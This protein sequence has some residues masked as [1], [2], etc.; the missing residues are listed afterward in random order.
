MLPTVALIGRPNVGKSTLFNRLLGRNKAL[1]HDRPGVTRDRIYAEVRAK[2]VRPFALVDTGGLVFTDAEGFELDVL[3]QAREAIRGSQAALLVVDAREGLT[4]M[5]QE[6]AGFLRSAG[7][8]LLCAANKVDGPEKE[9]LGAEFH[10][11]G[12]DVIPV[13]AAHGFGV[14]TLLQAVDD[15]LGGLRDARDGDWWA[16]EEDRPD[17]GL[18]MTMLGRPN[19]GKSSMVNALM[20][21]NRLIVSE[22]AGTTRD[23]VDVTFER[24]GKR[25][26]FV[27]TAGVRRRGRITD[28]LERFSTLRALRASKHAQVTVMVLDAT[29]GV[30][31]QDKKLLAFLDKEKT[32]FLAAVNKVDLVPRGALAQLRKDFEETLRICPHVPV[33]YTS[34]V[35]RA[36]LGGLLPLAEQIWEECGLRVGTGELNRAMKSALERHQPPTVKRRRAKFY[37]LTQPETHPPGFV[38]F[39]NDKDLVKESY[40]RYLEN[41]LRKMLGVKAAPMRVIFRSSHEKKEIK[42]K[43]PRRP[44]REP[45]RDAKP[46]QTSTKIGPSPAKDEAK[47][48]AAE[49][50]ARNTGGKA[51]AKTIPKPHKNTRP[52]KNTGPDRSE[53]SGKPARSGKPAKSGKSGKPVKKG[54]VSKGV[55]KKPG[56]GKSGAKA[57]RKK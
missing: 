42:G 37:Y 1:T 33:I 57:G 22:Q 25:Y 38:F 11:L 9:H 14:S 18:R 40:A 53:K 24:A 44:S 28:S 8:P 56:G 54:S 52:H 48:E 19:A 7:L 47:A 13:S 5:D 35:S 41:Q 34:C 30:T 26:T 36:G 4:P 2:A 10:A 29:A 27:D 51:K 46:R 43:P 16:D 12:L 20:G 3:D 21:E 39:V 15:L 23:S 6:V 31:M 17:Q 55:S 50:A 45:E 32:P 49:G